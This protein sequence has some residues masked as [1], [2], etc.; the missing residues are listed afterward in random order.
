MEVIIRELR[1]ED[2]PEVKVIFGEFVRY[3][4]QLDGIFEKIA[5][6]DEMWGDYVYKSHTQDENCKVLV[7]EFGGHIIGYCL[8]RIGQKPHSLNH[9]LM[10][11]N[12]F[13]PTPCRL[14]PFLTAMLPTSPTT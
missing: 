3:H 12:S 11:V 5:S 8:G 13:P 9:S 6:A 4:Q 14:Y 7:A 10:V 2:L 1:K